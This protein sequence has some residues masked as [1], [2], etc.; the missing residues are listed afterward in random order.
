MFL[1]GLGSFW[2]GF[3]GLGLLETGS[4]WSW[5][6]PCQFGGQF[7]KRGRLR[8]GESLRE[9]EYKFIMDLHVGCVTTSSYSREEITSRV[10]WKRRL[11]ASKVALSWFVCRLECISSIRPLRYFTVT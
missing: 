5:K 6:R 10:L 11:G 2:G 7:G 9:L 3:R 4:K 8:C 1:G